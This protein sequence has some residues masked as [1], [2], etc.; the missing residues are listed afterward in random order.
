MI[1]PTSVKNAQQETKQH[2]NNNIHDTPR[3]DAITPDINNAQKPDIALSVSSQ[4]QSVAGGGSTT[5]PTIYKSNLS[6]TSHHSASAD[7]DASTAKL[8]PKLRPTVPLPGRSDMFRG[9]SRKIIAN[10][11]SPTHTRKRRKQHA[12]NLLRVLAITCWA[13]PSMPSF[14]SSTT[15]DSSKDTQ[16]RL[17]LPAQIPIPSVTPTIHKIDKAFMFQTIGDLHPITNHLHIRT[18]VSLTSLENITISICSKSRQLR[19]IFETYTSGRFQTSA[20]YNISSKMRLD[21]ANDN[22]SKQPFRRFSPEHLSH[23]VGKPFIVYFATILQMLEQG[24]D[25]IN[26]IIQLA[27]NLFKRNQQHHR[28]KRQLLGGLSLLMGIYNTYELEQLSSRMSSINSNQDHLIAA[29]KHEVEQTTKLTEEM[30][31][32]DKQLIKLQRDVSFREYET[33]LTAI[34]SLQLYVTHA[35]IHDA[36]RTIDALYEAFAGRFSPK[37]VKSSSLRQ[38]LK[39][40]EIKALK[41]GFRLV[42]N[43]ITHIFEMT[44]SIY[45]HHDSGDIDVICHLPA[46]ADAEK[47]QVYQ[48]FPI[49]FPLPSPSRDNAGATPSTNSWNID[50]GDKLIVANQAAAIYYEMS[51]EELHDGT[52]IASSY[53]CRQLIQRKQSSTSSCLMAIFLSDFKMVHKLCQIK[54]RAIDEIAIS[55]NKFQ[56]LMFTKKQQ[57]FISCKQQN[58]LKP[59]EY[60]QTIEGLV[61]ISLPRHTTCSFATEKY[62][63]QTL[64][65]LETTVEASAIQID[66]PVSVLL[67]TSAQEIEAAIKSLEE[68]AITTFSLEDAKEEMRQIQYRSNDS[69][70]TIALTAV[71][72]ALSLTV[73]AML[74]AAYRRRAQKT[75]VNHR[76]EQEKHPKTTQNISMSTISTTETLTSTTVS[77]DKSSSSQQHQDLEELNRPIYSS[78][79]PKKKKG[80]R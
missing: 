21:V 6:A 56:I 4:R 3:E 67:N 15:T 50:H 38:G 36:S 20:T 22:I 68:R 28:E 58:H 60:D 18:T 33:R 61:M 9:P 34:L 55:I 10:P 8:L 25:Q 62:R 12:S 17:T 52:L 7:Q 72:A 5:T 47:L 77:D 75:S 43:S 73:A 66:V 23:K 76:R 42:S 14:S 45:I 74:F 32:L 80:D 57:A 59:L 31:R 13:L 26:S 39:E 2:Y 37:L 11:L 48:I 46:T 27:V 79:T 16:T 53:F 54:I 29:V 65:Y 51:K 19:N 41:A 64:P 24:C 35:Q 78:S 1:P 40:L 44:S 30:T 69:K 71:I 70:R 63:L 49:P